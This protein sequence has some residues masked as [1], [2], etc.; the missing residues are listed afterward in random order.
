MAFPKVSII[1]VICGNNIDFMS[2]CLISLIN[3][4]DYPNVEFIVVS[5]AGNEMKH[6]IS[7]IGEFN[8]SVKCV[9]RAHKNSNSSNRNLGARH[10]SSDTKY[11]LFT[12]SDVLYSNKQWLNNLVCISEENS[13]IGII[14][15]VDDH[16][17]IWG[18][19][20]FINNDTGILVNV[21]ISFKV[22][23]NF[24]VELMIIPGCNMLVRRSVFAY[25]GGWDEGFLPTY[26][27]DIDI[28]I[29]CLLTGHRVFG[30]HND[31][32]KHLYRATNENNS[33]ER[34]TTDEARCWLNIAAMRRLAMKYEGILPI[35]KLNTHSEWLD[36]IGNMR[37][38]GQMHLEKLDKHPPTVIDGKLNII[39]LPPNIT[40]EMV[41]T[42]KSISFD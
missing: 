39:Y 16:D 25:I 1:T 36:S 5:D 35:R 31:G 6:F 8:T 4:T 13:D 41:K 15:G 29:Q 20:C 21:P 3:N 28:C 18:H 26:G 24:P 23:P 42:Y 37:S 32:V 38:S 19:C 30:M 9:Y 22:L 34:I 14:G 33:C 2:K 11:L 27:E 7:S 40:S 10:A 17:N 12:D